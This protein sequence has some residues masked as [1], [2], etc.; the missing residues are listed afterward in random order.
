MFRIIFVLLLASTQPVSARM[1]QWVDP[2]SGSTQLSGKP[3]MWYRSAENGPRVFVF[4]KS[5]VIDDTGI[6]VSD[7][8]RDRLRQRAFLQADEDKE[9]ARQKILQSK[10][11]DAVLKQQQAAK[12]AELEKDKPS[13]EPIVEEDIDENPPPPLVTEP[14]KLEEMRKLIE[15]WEKAQTDKAKGILQN[16][17]GK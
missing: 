6:E 4:E 15:D 10:R 17:Q 2:D 14:S 3:P 1:Y 8:E 9:R 16:P 13:R 12:Q 7:S 11:F 5:K